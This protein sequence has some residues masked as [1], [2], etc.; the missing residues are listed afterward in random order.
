MPTEVNVDGLFE[1]AADAKNVAEDYRSAVTHTSADTSMCSSE[2]SMPPNSEYQ[3]LC[4]LANHEALSIF[5][6]I[7]QI[8]KSAMALANA[9]ATNDAIASS[10]F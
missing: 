5:L 1:I 3:E 2:D 7:H 8:A 4:Q 6:E 10:K 9:M